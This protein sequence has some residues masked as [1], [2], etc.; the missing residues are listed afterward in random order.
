M[1]LTARGYEVIAEAESAAT[2]LDAVERHAPHGVL[3]DVCLG[4]DDGFEVCGRLMRSR[5]RLAVLLA[6][7]DEHDPELVER[8][9]ARGLVR[10]SRL[11]QIDFG[12]FWSRD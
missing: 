12:E 1:L 5:P 10:K 3:L 8:S 9:G 7:A 2:A 11:S 6:S 4:D